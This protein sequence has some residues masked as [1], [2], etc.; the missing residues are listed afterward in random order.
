MAPALL[1]DLQSEVDAHKKQSSSHAAS[2]T[3]PSTAMERL[4]LDAPP[5]PE[6]FAANNV[7]QDIVPAI[8]DDDE[9]SDGEGKSESADGYDSEHRA[10]VGG[11]EEEEGQEEEDEKA[12]KEDEDEDAPDDSR[13]EYWDARTARFDEDYC[14]DDYEDDTYNI[15][16]QSMT[17]HQ[18]GGYVD[19]D[20]YYDG[21]PTNPNHYDVWL[22]CPERFANGEYIGCED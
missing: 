18:Y 7:A 9:G 5:A 6:L 11:D 20:Y 12:G 21:P 15:N 16:G 8:G 14:D 3:D 1:A 2:E 19:D 4:T 22:S 10:V 13:Q 17:R